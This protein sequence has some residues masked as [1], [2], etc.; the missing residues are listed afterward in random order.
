MHPESTGPPAAR[1][2]ELADDAGANERGTTVLAS[3]FER[4]DSFVLVRVLFDGTHGFSCNNGTGRRWLKPES[5]RAPSGA[6]DLGEDAAGRLHR[7]VASFGDPRR[8]VLHFCSRR[9]GRDG[10]RAGV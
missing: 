8:D 9:P 7:D 6:A 1:V 3:K 2:A 10:D 5:D 4:A